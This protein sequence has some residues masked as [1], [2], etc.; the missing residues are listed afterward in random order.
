MDLWHPS[1]VRV[2]CPTL[3]PIKASPAHS[4][5]TSLRF[6]GESGRGRRHRPCF[7]LQSRGLAGP[8]LL[9]CA[10][11]H[12]AIRA[13]SRLLPH[14]R[15]P[16]PWIPPACRLPLAS[17]RLYRCRL[18]RRHAPSHRRPLRHHPGPECDQMDPPRAPGRRAACFLPQVLGRP[19]I[20][21]L[22][23]PRAATLEII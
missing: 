2:P 4:I 17:R 10:A 1:S 13:K 7:G 5:Q 9:T 12:G 8:A 20:R 21:R 6:W 3:Q 22:P 18:G 15:H 23:D 11:V 19:R 16:R 14:V